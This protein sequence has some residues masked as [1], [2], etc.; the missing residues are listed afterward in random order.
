MTWRRL[1]RYPATLIGFLIVGFF[2]LMALIGQWVA[3]YGYS[4]QELS[5]RLQPPSRQ[6]L[7]GTDQFGRDVLSRV[8]VGSRD[9]YIVAGSGALLAVLLGLTVGLIAGYFGGAVDEI[10]MR[11]IDVLLAMP[12]LLLAMI[13][14]FSLGTSRINVVLVVG[15]LYIP[16]VSRVVRSVVLDL[17]TRQFVEA[18]KLRG[19][20]SLYI[21]FR[22]IL[23]S[24][25]PPLA[26]EAS[27]R[28]SYAI[29]LVA[30]LG[31]LGLGVQPPSPDWGL[32]VGE[33][34]NY[35]S[36]AQWALLA[37]AGAVI[38]LVIGVAFMSDGLRRMLLPGGV[39]E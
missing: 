22:E 38:I 9:V 39:S 6:Y 12:P 7:L 34:R 5:D 4:D 27:M 36:Q 35:F 11:L 10:L 29:F 13:V 18:A 17:K 15:F 21:M 26:V 3:P 32:M 24:V 14:L 8:L 19:E 25:M 1:K 33:A 2:L 30:S 20:S 23:P 37:P 28:F 16:M 31:F